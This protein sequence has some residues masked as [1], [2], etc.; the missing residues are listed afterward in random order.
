MVSSVWQCKSA[1]WRISL[2]GLGASV[3]EIEHPKE[4]ILKI[5]EEK[6]AHEIVA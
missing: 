6:A 3:A 5:I 1:A 4:E 2:G